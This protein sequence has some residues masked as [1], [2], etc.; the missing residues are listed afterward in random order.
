MLSEVWVSLGGCLCACP[1]KQFIPSLESILSGDQFLTK[2]G[3][4]HTHNSPATPGG[5]PS[6]E[7]CNNL[8]GNWRGGALFGSLAGDPYCKG[9]NKQG[10][11]GGDMDP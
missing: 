4:R 11:T 5:A 7:A 9:R 3:P 10:R 2:K 1:K 6:P 8:E